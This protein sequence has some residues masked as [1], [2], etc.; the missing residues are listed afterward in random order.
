VWVGMRT[1][2]T[3]TPLQE[4]FADLGQVGFIVWARADVQVVQ[5][6]AAV[7]LTGAL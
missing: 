2:F 6:S 7:V 1:A 3:L 4:R 5:P